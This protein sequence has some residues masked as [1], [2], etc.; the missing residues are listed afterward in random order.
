MF[1]NRWRLRNKSVS[2]P[3]NP[4]LYIHHHLG[5]GDMI[6]CNGMVR[7]LLAQLPE[8]Q[9][10]RVFCKQSYSSMVEWMYRDDPRI[11]L[12][13]IDQKKRETPEVRRV[14]RAERATNF[15]SV[16]HKAMR[17]LEAAHPELFFDQ[18]FYLQ[19]GMPYGNRFSQ[20]YWH[21]D[22][23]E[24]ERVFRKL[25][26]EGEYA[27]VHD[28]PSRGFQLKTEHIDIPIVRNDVTESIFHMGLLLERAKEIHC[29]ESSIRCMIESLDV[30]NV[31][32][33]W[34]AFRYGSRALGTATCKNWVTVPYHLAE[35][36]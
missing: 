27:F 29:M 34:H 25:A 18:L 24:E 1:A 35:A 11:E 13:C 16:G 14:L 3:S 22:L 17:P 28:D 26:P 12:R 36:A 32:L 4:H 8:E 2:N 10:V 33:Y 20:C 15:L 5:L 23:E 19:L 21:R 31:Q 30:E 7:A 9:N 6:H